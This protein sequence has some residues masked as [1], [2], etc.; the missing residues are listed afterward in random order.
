MPFLGMRGTGDWVANQ[1][2]E[3]WRETILY[4]YPNGSAPITAMLSMMR[5]EQ[6]DDPRFHWWTKNLPKQA[7][8][9]TGIFSD[10]ALTAAFTGAGAEDQ[11]VYIQA[12]E[13]EIQEFRISHQVLLRQESDYEVD[14]VGKVTGRNL[15]GADSYVAVKL[16]EASGG[17]LTNVDNLLVIG[18]LNP[19]GGTR[20]N[21]LSYDPVEYDNL[22]QIFR[23]SLEITRT[24][25]KTRLRTGDAYA[26]L[27]R[28]ALELHSIEMEKAIIWGTKSSKIGSNGKPERSTNG[29]I[30]FTTTNAPDNVSDYRESNVDYNGQA[31][32][33][34]GEKWFDEQ[35]EK[36]FRYGST[37]KLA[38]CG[39]GALLGLNKLAKVGGDINLEPMTTDYGLQVVRWVTPFGILY[40]KRH[41]LFSYEPTNRHSMVI[42][43]PENLLYRY[44]DDTVF[45]PDTD[46]NNNQGK[47]GTDEEFL[48]ECGLEQHHPMTFGY[49]NGVGLD[50]TQA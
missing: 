6:T 18:N 5:S 24:A 38:L 36:I 20:P 34:G 44:I 23:T 16:L 29:I 22:T 49:L 17:V 41:P 31:W 28:E 43:E 30:K 46:R 9:I 47:D 7:A 48:T 19:E 8:S 14:T 26:E 45:I 1:R 21:A 40:L 42:F 33:V 10:S 2:P 32:D 37:E 13:A 11:T 39:S 15:S 12:S 27:K 35:L 50:N 25:R 4:L 3:N